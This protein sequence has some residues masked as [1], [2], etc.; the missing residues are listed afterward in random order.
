M[1]PKSKMKV[2]EWQLEKSKKFCLLDS[3]IYSKKTL[4]FIKD[5]DKVLDIGCGNCSF[6]DYIKRYRDV[7]MYGFD[8]LK[9]S[10]EIAKK[11]G[12]TY[13]SFLNTNEKFN[14]I[15]MFE[16]IEHLDIQ[17]KIEYA[18]KLKDL[19]ADGGRLIIT[20][21]NVQSLLTFQNYSNNLEHKFPI[22]NK[23]NMNFLFG[24]NFKI[25]HREY[26]K[27]WVNP[28]KILH[29]LIIGFGYTAIFNNV[30]YVLKKK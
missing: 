15:V 21:P 30:M 9:E 10:A 12:Y 23:H 16:V 2:H 5:K 20:F 6:F 17:T 18:A 27:P 8:I 1:D 25:V 4:K 24:D 29:S 14:V 26:L 22:M 7:K 13:Y 19:L 11:K 28:L 3:K